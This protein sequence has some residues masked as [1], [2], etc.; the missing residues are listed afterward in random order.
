MTKIPLMTNPLGRYWNQPKI[1][2]I[3][4]DDKS[5]LMTEQAFKNL[6]EYSFSNPSGT[7]EG[8]MWKRKTSNGLFLCWYQSIPNNDK[9]IDIV[10]R[11]IIIIN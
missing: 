4:V 8:K 10:S 5:A 1:T 11:E 9:E 2:E 3:E 7:Y 6:A